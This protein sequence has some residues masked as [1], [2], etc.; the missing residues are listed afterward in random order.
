MSLPKCSTNELD[1]YR[2]V[3]LGR[4]RVVYRYRLLPDRWP[5]LILSAPCVVS[6]AVDQGQPAPCDGVLISAERAREAV[7]DKR[8]VNLR[9]TFECDPCPACPE[10]PPDRTREVASASFF[11]GFVLGLLLLFVR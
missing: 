1:R 2:A 10:S 9:R 6:Q 8:E 7:A 3:R 5:V 11:A 4:Y